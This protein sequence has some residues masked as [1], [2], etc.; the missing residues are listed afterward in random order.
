MKGV[1]KMLGESQKI[2]RTNMASSPWMDSFSNEI[3]EGNEPVLSDG[4]INPFLELEDFEIHGLLL[5]D[6]LI[7]MVVVRILLVAFASQDQLTN[8]L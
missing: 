5:D 2:D 1:I 3:S 6:T 7:P 4:S 8:T